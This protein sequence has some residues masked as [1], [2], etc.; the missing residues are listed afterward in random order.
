MAME[1]AKLMGSVLATQWDLK[2]VKKLERVSV[3][4]SV[5]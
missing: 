4:M 5:T 3:Q 2:M 1:S